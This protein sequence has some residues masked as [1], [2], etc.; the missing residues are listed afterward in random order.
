MS[1]LNLELSHGS[2]T[3]PQEIVPEVRHPERVVHLSN[4]IVSQR[5]RVERKSARGWISPL[6]PNTI[7]T[8]FRV[9]LEVIL[10][11]KLDDAAAVL[12]SDLSEIIQRIV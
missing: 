4:R 2:A 7:H 5:V 11:G 1:T 8:V 12:V 10:E 6:A 3:S 9:S